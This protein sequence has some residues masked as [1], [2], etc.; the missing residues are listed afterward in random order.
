MLPPKPIRVLV[1]DSHEMSR[2]ALKVFVETFDD[3]ELVGEAGD[4]S[5][6]LQLCDQLQP[7]IA[8]MSINLNFVDGIPTTRT[9]REQFP[10]VNVVMLSYL[11]HP[12][13]LEAA[14]TAGASSYL[15]KGIS[16]NDI[17]AAIRTA[18]R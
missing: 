10:H 5:E 13:D 17:A 4:G 16:I 1:A 7:D 6:V 15:I 9:I 12:Q 8:L 18:N 3:L 14:I 2:Y 11:D